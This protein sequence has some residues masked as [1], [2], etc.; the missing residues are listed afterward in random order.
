[1]MIN[2]FSTFDPAT[3]M[4]TSMNWLSLT[5]PLLLIPL[6]MWSTSS[7]H[8]M[9]Q[10]IISTKIYTEISSM[11]IKTPKGTITML[12]S[13]LWFIMIS[14]TTG[15]LPYT[16]TASSHLCISTSLALTAWL[17]LNM[18]AW[19]KKTNHMLT[20]MLPLGTP[21]S[22]MMFMVCIET[23]SNIIRPLT[24]AVRL[25]ANM[26]AGHLL[27]SLI[28]SS[29]MNSNLMMML[30]I[31]TTELTLMM[32]ETT[33]AFIQSYVFMTLITLYLNETN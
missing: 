30:P 1:M 32:L 2:L 13:I 4:N 22:L 10:K 7:Q 15:L 14:N 6:T 28:S 20:H 8:Q 26:I 29:M 12:F 5:M 9:I 31:T 19:I 16:F 24:L 23:I 3:S 33:V 11:N 21:T 18:F 17:S 25:T 27:I